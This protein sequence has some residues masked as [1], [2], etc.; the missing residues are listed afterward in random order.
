[1]LAREALRIFR[2]RVQRGVSV[3]GGEGNGGQ[4]RVADEGEQ[5]SESCG[6]DVCELVCAG[7]EPRRKG[8]GD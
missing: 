8:L 1:M 2:C 3:V 7:C 4:R 5:A 6:V